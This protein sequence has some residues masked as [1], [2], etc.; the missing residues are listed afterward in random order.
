M[1]ANPYSNLPPSAFWKSGVTQE[2]P[3][4]I[5]GIYKK[6][7]TSRQTPRLQLRDHALPNISRVI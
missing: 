1:G 6:N 7:S 4:S 5:E 3:Y 2:N